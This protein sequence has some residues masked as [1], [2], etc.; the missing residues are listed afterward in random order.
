MG[1]TQTEPP[2]DAR[3]EDGL[4]RDAFLSGRVS[5]WQPSAGYRA[6]IDAV[7][8]AAACPAKPLQPVLD[9]GC[10]VGVAGLCLAA[11]TGARVVGVERQAEYAALARRNGLDTIEADLSVLPPSL[12]KV[13]FAHVIANPPYY[14]AAEGPPPSNSGRAQALQ[15]ETPLEIWIDVAARKLVPKGYLTMIQRASRLRDVL[16]ALPR[17]FGGITVQPIE[18]R[19]G[20]E[21]TLIVVQARKEGRAPLRLLAPFILHRGDHHIRDGT[22]DY[23]PQARAILRDGAALF[24]LQ[25][26]K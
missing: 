8:L 17:R 21:A 19:A 13:S 5:V 25:D 1:K 3:D 9:L 14:T 11:R 23:T 24:A 7:L 16:A 2:P 20:R 22:D 15:E 12:H 4:T 18:P 10:G 6:G 26:P